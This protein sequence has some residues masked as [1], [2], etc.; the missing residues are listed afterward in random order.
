MIIEVL[1]HKCDTVPN[2]KEVFENW[3]ANIT[4]H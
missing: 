4:A 1:G 2:G 3:I